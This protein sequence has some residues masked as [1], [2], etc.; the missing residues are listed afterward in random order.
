MTKP[1]I[2]V[3]AAVISSGIVEES[4]GTHKRRSRRHDADASAQGSTNHDADAAAKRPAL[5]TTGVLGQNGQMLAAAIGN[6]RAQLAAILVDLNALHDLVGPT[7]ET[8]RGMTFLKDSDSP[9]TRARLPEDDCATRLE[10]WQFGV[11]EWPADHDER[12]ALANYINLLDRLLEMIRRS[13]NNTDRLQRYLEELQAS[14]ARVMESA[15]NQSVI[16]RIEHLADLF[17]RWYLL[18][19]TGDLVRRGEL[20]KQFEAMCEA[21]GQVAEKFAAVGSRDTRKLFAGTASG[22]PDSVT[23]Q[24]VKNVV[25]LAS[26][27]MDDSSDIGR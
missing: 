5:P 13:G 6:L 26:A 12:G 11:T 17:G 22:Q 27:I 21:C 24:F 19:C 23:T 8:I 25:M 3:I 10:L 9:R 15:Q 1:M 16:H 4:D 18:P 2:L 7:Q 20:G 14:K